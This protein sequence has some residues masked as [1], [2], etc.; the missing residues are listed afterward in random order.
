MRGAQRKHLRSW[1]DDELSNKIKGDVRDIVD[2][3]TWTSGRS[4]SEGGVGLTG[5]N[6]LKCFLRSVVRYLNRAKGH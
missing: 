1:L 5:E 3:I 2:T 4:P 6:L